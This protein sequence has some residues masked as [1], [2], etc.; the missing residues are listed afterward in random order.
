MRRP[1]SMR[2][3]GGFHAFPG[4]ALD[5]QDYSDRTAGISTLGSGEAEARMAGAAGEYPALGFFVC[6]L[7]ELFEEVGILFVDDEEGPG[8]I[9][10]DE[11]RRARHRLLSGDLNFPELLET[12]GL[13]LATHRL[14]FHTRWTAPEG[15]PVRFDARFF[16]APA[17]GEPDPNPDEVDGIDWKTPS[18]IMALAEAGAVMLAPPTLATVGGLARFESA[19]ALLSGSPPSESTIRKIER[20]SQLVRRLVAPNPSIMTGPGT[21][22]Y[23]VGTDRLVVIDPGSME[24]SHLETVASAGRIETVV[25]THGHADH[26]S[27]AL[28]LA[29]KAGAE[30]AVPERFAATTRQGFRRRLTDGD[31]LE[32][33]G[34]RLRVLDTPGHASDHICLWLEEEKAL[35]SGDLVLGEGTTVISPPDGNLIQY[36]ASLEKVLALG[37]ARLYPA[38]FDPRDDAVSWIGWYISHRREREEQILGALATS[39]RTIPEIVAEVYASYPESLHPIAERSVLA[40]LDKL[41]HEGRVTSTGGTYQVSPQPS[42]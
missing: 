20:H 26:Y 38:H 42:H 34:A 21:N 19:E 1:R 39:K 16:V 25:I 3:F 5:H 9:N 27:G 13:K 14:R 40:H 15:M 2:A 17:A 10:R 11:L 18:Q 24:P 4:G 37:P 32:A 22:T 33:E 29:Q 36:L 30:V 31:Y 41:Q 23:L 7:R 28:E 8:A 12:L 35:F 6:A